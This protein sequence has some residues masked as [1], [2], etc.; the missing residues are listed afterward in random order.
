MAN[1]T[2]TSQLKGN[3]Y[4]NPMEEDVY[5]LIKDITEI[6]D[7]FNLLLASECRQMMI[8]KSV[9]WTGWNR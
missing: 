7:S 9:I 6:D 1:I 3:V 8:L 4:I 5:I 2:L